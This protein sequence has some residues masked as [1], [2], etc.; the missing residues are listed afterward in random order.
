[1][2]YSITGFENSAATSRIMCI[3]SDSKALRWLR[4]YSILNAIFDFV[5]YV[6]HRLLYAAL[7]C[8]YGY[9]GPL[10]NFKGGRD[11]RKVHYQPC[12][13]AG[14]ET[15]DVTTLALLYGGGDVYYYKVIAADNLLCCVAH[16]IG[17]A[18]EAG[19]C[20]YARRGK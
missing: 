12:P 13:C 2:E 7:C 9:V 17:G 19:N 3:D 18:E 15:L 11:A 1:M 5:Y 14:I 8:V 20:N 10:G 6:V 4:L 16:S